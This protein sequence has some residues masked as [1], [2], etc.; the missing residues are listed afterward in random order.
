[1]IIINGHEVD[2][3]LVF[4]VVDGAYLYA[5][6]AGYEEKMQQI[7]YFTKMNQATGVRL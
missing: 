5:S 2:Q 6:V 7:S 3:R 1:M 4:G